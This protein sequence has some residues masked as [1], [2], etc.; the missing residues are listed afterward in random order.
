MDKDKLRVLPKITTLHKTY[1]HNTDNYFLGVPPDGV[2]LSATSPRS[3]MRRATPFR[4][5]L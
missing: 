2:G 4:C 1:L 3:L 5:I